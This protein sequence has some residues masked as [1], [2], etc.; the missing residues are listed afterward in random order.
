VSLRSR[1]LLVVLGLVAVTLTATNVV[2]YRA[3]RS[4]LLD[5]V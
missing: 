5:R 1:L 4:F 2:T 3:L